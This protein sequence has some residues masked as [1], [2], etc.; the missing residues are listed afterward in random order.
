MEGSDGNIQQTQINSVSR[1]FTFL[2]AYKYPLRFKNVEVR[3]V[4][5]MIFYLLH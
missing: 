4:S 3:S 2:F 5:Q 1:E